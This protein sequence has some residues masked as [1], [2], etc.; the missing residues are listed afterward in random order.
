[1]LFCLGVAVDLLRDGPR[2]NSIGSMLGLPPRVFTLCQI[3]LRT[4]PRVWP[5]FCSI[6]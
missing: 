5:F 1:M 3:L 6:F 2:S 4:P